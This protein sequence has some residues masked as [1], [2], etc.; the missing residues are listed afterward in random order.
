MVVL[1]RRA[2]LTLV[3]V[4]SMLMASVPA[5]LVMGNSQTSDS[6]KTINL[7]L[8]VDS[9]GSMAAETDTGT[10]R[11]DAAK[12]VLTEVISAIPDVEGVNV[13][14]RVYGHE[15]DNTDAGRDVSC[16]SSELL[17]P[18]EGVDVPALTEQVEAL[19]PVGWTPLGFSLEEAAKDFEQPASD[20]VVNAI[21]MVTDGLET[22]NA[23]PVAIASE[24]RDSDAGIITHVIGFG[25][26]P[27]EQEILSG[28]AEAGDGQL[29]GSNNAG[30]LMSAL[31]EILEELEVVEVTG[32]GETRDSPLGIGRIGT[33]GDYEVSVLSVEP[34]ADEIVM[35]ENEF[36]EPPAEGNQFFIARIAVTYVGS[37]TGTPWLDLSFKSVGGKSTSYEMFNNTCGVYPDDATAIGEL[38]EGG[39]AEFNVC[40]QIASADEDSLVMYIEPNAFGTGV[41]PVWFSL[42]P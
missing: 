29:L 3:I 41:E 8:I 14:F 24:L 22:C 7:Q 16:R 30:Q 38:F 21:V 1:T 25:T 34:N 36:N 9:S 15:G 35:A 11:I 26:K 28:I 20:D 23:D 18:M 6:G 2:V 12:T 17:V 10:L 19:Q 39:S 32:T 37:T 5:A 13:G 40:W 27:E 4:V 31:F 42:E 33:I